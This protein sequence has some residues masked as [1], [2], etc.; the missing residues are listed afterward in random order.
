MSAQLSPSPLLDEQICFALYN[1]S[2][3]LTSRY[4]DLLA[5]LGVTYPQY[6]ALLVLWEHGPTTVGELGD[7]LHLDSGTL[8]PLLRRMVTA[9]LVEKTRRP[10]DE[11]TVVVSV[12]AAGE[13]LRERTAGIPDSIC[14]ATGLD[15]DG[16]FALRDQLAELSAHVRA[17]TA[18]ATAAPESSPS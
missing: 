8:S 3:A 12:T 6:L 18:S 2:R 4:R 11:R 1:A 7:R 17:S 10:Q 9:G 13:A 16:I 5:P 15:P 14:A